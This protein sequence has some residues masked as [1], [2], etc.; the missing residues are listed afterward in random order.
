MKHLKTYQQINELHSDTTI[1]AWFKAISNGNIS[2]ANVFIKP[3]IDK[4]GKFPIENINNKKTIFN[5]N[6]IEFINTILVET[7]NGSYLYGVNYINEISFDIMIDYSIDDKFKILNIYSDNDES[8]LIFGDIDS[9]KHELFNRLSEKFYSY[10]NIDGY[11]NLEKYIYKDKLENYCIDNNHDYNDSDIY[12]LLEFLE[13]ELGISRVVE[14]FF[15][16]EQYATDKTEKILRDNK[17]NDIATDY[18]GCISGHEYILS[19]GTEY[20]IFQ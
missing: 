12:E 8:Q 17:I 5:D 1:S 16:I 6:M 20:Y 14:T 19:N 13:T 4:Y 2:Q 18:L 15:N 7:I 10:W 3:Y 11:S 9:L